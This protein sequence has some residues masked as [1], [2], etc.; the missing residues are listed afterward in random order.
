MAQII[1]HCLNNFDILLVYQCLY[2]LKSA[3]KVIRIMTFFQVNVQRAL[4]AKNISHARGATI[5]AGYLKILPLFIII[6]PGMISRVLYT[7]SDIK[8]SMVN[9]NLNLN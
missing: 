5:T 1:K 9:L 8:F 6:L 2:L 3:E 4:A 7:G